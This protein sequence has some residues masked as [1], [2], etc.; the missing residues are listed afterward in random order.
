M[1]GCHTGFHI[2]FAS[3]LG[4][5]PAPSLMPAVLLRGDQVWVCIPVEAPFVVL[6]AVL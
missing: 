1:V 2:G 3:D 6:P 4:T 5:S